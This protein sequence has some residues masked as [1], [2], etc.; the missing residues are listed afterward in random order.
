MKT[1]N[2]IN[3]NGNASPNQFLLTDDIKSTFQSYSTTIAQEFNSGKIVLDTNALNYSKTTSKHLFIFLGM[4]RKQI[5]AKIKSGE[6]TLTN[7]NK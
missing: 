3:N 6:I 5:E 7:L 2:L 4:D 1:S